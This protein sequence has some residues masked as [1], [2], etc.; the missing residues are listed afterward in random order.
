MDERSQL[1]AV[2]VLVALVPSESVSSYVLQMQLDYLLFIAQSPIL[3]HEL[4]VLN[5]G[6]HGVS[7]SSCFQCLH[8]RWVLI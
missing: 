1:F 5:N 3:G 2:S 7:T 4:T 8:E 6:L